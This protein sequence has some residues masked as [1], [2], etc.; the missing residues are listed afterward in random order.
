MWRRYGVAGHERIKVYLWRHALLPL[1]ETRCQFGESI[2]LSTGQRLFS[3]YL[4][5]NTSLFM[6]LARTPKEGPSISLTMT[7]DNEQ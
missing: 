7:T 3:V 2:G 1:D 5:D 6:L 4:R